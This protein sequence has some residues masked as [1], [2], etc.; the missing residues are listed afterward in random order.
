MRQ[1]NP[2]LANQHSSSDHCIW[3]H[4][5]MFNHSIC[6][7]VKNVDFSF[8]RLW[9]TYSFPT[10][11]VW[12]VYSSSQSIL[13]HTFYM[14]LWIWNYPI[15]FLIRFLSHTNSAPNLFFPQCI[16]L[17]GSARSPWILIFFS[18]YHA[19]FLFPPNK[20][21]K[22]SSSSHPNSHSRYYTTSSLNKFF[23]PKLVINYT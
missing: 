7:H 11:N 20:F 9:P 22:Q 17:C 4:L 3:C 12:L 6:F 16:Y 10:F 15:N 14:S 23:S 13:V 5:A 1:T 8:Y 2:R 18:L 21:F 19:C